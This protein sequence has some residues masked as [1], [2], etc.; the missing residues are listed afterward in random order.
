VKLAG[1]LKG[2]HVDLIDCSSGGN[3]PFQ[4]IQIGPLYQTSFAERLRKETGIMTGAVGLITTFQQAEQILQNQQADVIVLAR[5]ILRDPYFPL[6]AAKEL[7]VDVP[8]PPQYDR[9]KP[10]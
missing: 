10:M 3:S 8:W 6:H 4:K 2:E 5:Q 7:N 1:I 9:A